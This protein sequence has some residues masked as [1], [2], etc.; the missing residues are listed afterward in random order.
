MQRKQEC[1]L[2]R[3]G[4]GADGVS[5][6]NMSQAPQS[7]TPPNLGGHCRTNWEADEHDQV[8]RELFGE[9]PGEENDAALAL[10][11]ATASAAN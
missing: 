9:A 4:D 10:T 1:E 6:A 3:S 2:L 11:P 7:H 5:L 8:K